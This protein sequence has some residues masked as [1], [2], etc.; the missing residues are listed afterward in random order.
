[1]RNVTTGVG[2]NFSRGQRRRFAPP[3]QVADVAMETNVHKTLYSLYTT[4]KNAPCYGNSH[5]NTLIWKQCSFSH[6]SDVNYCISLKNGNF[7]VRSVSLS[8]WRGSA[9][10][11]METK[12]TL[13][14]LPWRKRKLP[15]HVFIKKTIFYQSGR[16]HE[17]PAIYSADFSITCKLTH[18]SDDPERLMLIKLNR[19]VRMKMICAYASPFPNH[20]KAKVCNRYAVCA[21]S[22]ICNKAWI[23]L[24][25]YRS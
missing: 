9:T 2:S 6:I 13:T 25:R 12:F 17:Q 8:A 24:A 14:W 22:I 3:F 23:S 5:R 21:N 16:K 10:Q 18:N 20:E 19:S 7:F 15:G 11:G 4:Q 1:M